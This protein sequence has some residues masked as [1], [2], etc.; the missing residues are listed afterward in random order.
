MDKA[1]GDFKG[2]SDHSHRLPL[3]VGMDDPL[4]QVNCTNPGGMRA[5]RI[6][7]ELLA[8]P[9]PHADKLVKYGNCRSA[10]IV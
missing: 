5:G 8:Q 1:E 2:F 10:V 4:I 7:V 6:G 9:C 3:V